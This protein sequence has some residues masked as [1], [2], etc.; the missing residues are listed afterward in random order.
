MH[1]QLGWWRVSSSSCLSSVRV[2]STWV[3][4]PP[5]TPGEERPFST[6]APILDSGPRCREFALCD[7]EADGAK[8]PAGPT[9]RSRPDPIA[10][11]PIL[12]S[13]VSS[14]TAVSACHPVRVR[15]TR[16]NRRRIRPPALV[17]SLPWLLPPR[18]RPW[19]RGTRAMADRSCTPARTVPEKLARAADYE[20]G[21]RSGGPFEALAD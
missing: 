21:R 2:Y 12:A 5:T 14:P 18:C 6:C 8:A 7:A 4:S 16:T 3:T 11:R 10:C 15:L 17:T 1:Q 20:P 13:A 19:M 9:A